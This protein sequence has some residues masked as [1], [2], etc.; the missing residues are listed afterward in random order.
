LV[1]LSALCMV[2]KRFPNGGETG[3]SGALWNMM[4]AEYLSFSTR[5]RGGWHQADKNTVEMVR[6]V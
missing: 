2:S 6:Q 1:L 5:L 3:F 4:T